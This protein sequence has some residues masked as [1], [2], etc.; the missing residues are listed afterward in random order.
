MPIP[1]IS[2]E[3]MR[4]ALKELEQASYNHDQ[5]AETL[6]GTLI[7]H[8]APD[9]RD[10]ARD[11]Y[12][13]CRFGQWYYKSGLAALKDY[14]GFAE[15][16]LEHERMHRYATS[17]LRASMDGLPISI[18]DYERFVT[19]L[20]R[21]HLEIATVQRDL[22]SSLFNL[23]PLTGTPS[24]VSMLSRLRELQEFVRRDQAC[25]IAMMDL[26]D[27]KS[28]N[29][30]YGHPVGDK[31]L[32]GCAHYLMAHLRPYDRVFRY[33]GEEFLICLSD[34]DLPTG[35]D[36][37]DRMREELAALRFPANGSGTFQVTVS[38]GVAP[39]DGSVSVEQSI[40]R[41]DKALYFA[42][43]AGKNRVVA[44]DKTMVE[45]LGEQAQTA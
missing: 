14:P 22:E 28:V 24:R 36:I 16:G 42:K 8:L 5:W 27:F 30:K 7:C 37:I 2:D 12:R 33:G 18:N 35:H 3:Q 31:V 25:T 23:D 9:D 6:Y 39:L 17:L 26:D 15:I 13:C 4:A 41:A 43:A 19:A 11:S 10:I 38:F 34:T 20:K 21:L 29:D 45:S 1:T 44:W 40:D 32:I